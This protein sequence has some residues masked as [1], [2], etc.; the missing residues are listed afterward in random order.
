MSSG[1][2]KSVQK[3]RACKT[4]SF[5]KAVTLYRDFKSAHAL[6][7]TVM[8]CKCFIAR[9]VGSAATVIVKAFTDMVLGLL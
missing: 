7:V 1:N 3:P 2:E 9:K 8:C 4:K 5:F 6:F